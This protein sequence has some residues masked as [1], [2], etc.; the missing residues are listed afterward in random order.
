M[1]SLRGELH[2]LATS[3][4]REVETIQDAASLTAAWPGLTHPLRLALEVEF[5]LKIWAQS[6]GLSSRKPKR[7]ISSSQTL[8]DVSRDFLKQLEETAQ[9]GTP[10]SRTN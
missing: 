5:K 2:S 10:S 4:I 7:E 8:L 6:Y 3:A 1:G 9:N